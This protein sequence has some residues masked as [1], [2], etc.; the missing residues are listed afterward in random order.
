MKQQ[1]YPGSTHDCPVE[2]TRLSPRIIHNQRPAWPGLTRGPSAHGLDPW[3]S[4]SSG[5]LVNLGGQDVDARN[6]SGQGGTYSC[7]LL[8]RLDPTLSQLLNRTAVGFSRRSM[9]PRDKRAGDG[10]GVRTAFVSCREDTKMQRP[11]KP[12]SVWSYL[13]TG[14]PIRGAKSPAKG[15]CGQQLQEGEGV[16]RPILS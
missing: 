8:T 15:L 1:A 6:K 4:T 5:A 9:D 10:E 2:G 12:T 11:R 13:T 7:I 14:S 3:A 16:S